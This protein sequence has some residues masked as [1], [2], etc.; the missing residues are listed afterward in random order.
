MGLVCGVG[1][2][3]VHCHILPGLDDGAGDAGVSFSMARIAAGTGIEAICATVH[4]LGFGE[5]YPRVRNVVSPDVYTDRLR[6]LR[7]G[8]K[9]LGIPVKILTGMEI[10]VDGSFERDLDRQMYF[11]LGGTK[12]LLIE[13]PFDTE[14]GAMF[15]AANT[16]L[17]YGYT[18]VVA[19]PERYF[20]MADEPEISDGLVY[21]GC[22]L[23]AN[24]GSFFG[25]FG[26]SAREAAEYMLGRGL[27]SAVASDAHSDERRTPSFRKVAS[28]LT[29]KT[30]AETTLSLLRDGPARLCGYAAARED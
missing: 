8:L 10:F 14:P 6:F 18:P 28:Y 21:S 26:E 4:S 30:G 23:Q 1:Y 2:V 15:E 22:L 9:D 16:A 5:R 29:E 17:R 25:V 27:L 24:K 7:R 13:F 12:N 11:P 20:C 3:D 19:H